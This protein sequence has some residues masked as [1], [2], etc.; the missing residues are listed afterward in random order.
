LNAGSPAVNRFQLLSVVTRVICL[1]LNS[2]TPNAQPFSSQGEIR[3]HL[4]NRARR[5]ER[6]VYRSCLLCSVVKERAST[7][8]RPVWESN[9]SFRLERAGSSADRRTGRMLLRPTKKARRRVDTGP[10]WLIQKST[11]CHSRSASPDSSFAIGTNEFSAAGVWVPGRSNMWH[12]TDLHGRWSC[13][14]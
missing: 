12:L 7:I 2:Q 10:D 1:A 14:V 3:T 9:P 11:R 6:R 5:S 4:P 8:E 13:L